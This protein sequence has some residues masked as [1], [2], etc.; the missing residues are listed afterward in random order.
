MFKQADLLVDIVD[1][2]VFDPFLKT[3]L[4]NVI[5]VDL[6]SQ[7]LADSFLQKEEHVLDFLNQITVR[8]VSHENPGFHLFGIPDFVLNRIHVFGFQRFEMR[9]VVHAVENQNV[10]DIPLQFFHQHCVINRNLSLFQQT[11][12]DPLNGYQLNHPIKM[13]QV[14]LKAERS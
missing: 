2:A 8:P 14:R 12:V 1:F 6:H 4:T 9:L 3:V 7:R 11:L 13:M 5:S 10:L